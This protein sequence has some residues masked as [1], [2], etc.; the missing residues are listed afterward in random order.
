MTRSFGQKINDLSTSLTSIQQRFELLKMFKVLKVL[1]G[2]TNLIHLKLSK[3][4]NP[5]LIY[6]E[7]GFGNSFVSMLL[8]VL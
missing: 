2:S 8:P 6:A 5:L 7:Y 1:D 3:K 4:K